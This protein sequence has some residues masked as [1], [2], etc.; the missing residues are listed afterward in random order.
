MAEVLG[1]K[2]PLRESQVKAET[3]EDEE[4]ATNSQVIDAIPMRE[5]GLGP[6]ENKRTD[7]LDEY[8]ILIAGGGVSAGYLCKELVEREFGFNKKRITRVF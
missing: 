5:L 8:D 6:L 4:A 7:I 3:R 1:E 2:E